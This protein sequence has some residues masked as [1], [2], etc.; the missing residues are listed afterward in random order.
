MESIQAPYR[1]V[2]GAVK[3]SA[4]LLSNCI[5]TRLMQER[6][7]SENTHSLNTRSEFL[8]CTNI[9]LVAAHCLNIMGDHNLN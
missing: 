7:V 1:L 2:Y 5:Y 6:G 9:R 4:Q 3:G 8:Y